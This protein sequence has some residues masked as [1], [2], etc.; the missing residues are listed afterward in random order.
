MI[1]TL[2]VFFTGKYF[3]IPNYQ[4]NYAWEIRNID[5]L[6]DDI[7]EGMDTNVG[8]YI[9]TFILSQSQEFNSYDVVDG[10]QR[11]TTLT[12]ILNSTINKL[13]C[14]TD[15]IINR[16]KFIQ[17]NSTKKWKLELLGDNDEFFKDLLSS[18]PVTPVKKSQRL[19]Q[20]A[21]NHINSRIQEIKSSGKENEFLNFIKNLE[22]M[23]FTESDSGKAIRIFQTVND[24]GK[25][26][27]NI[28]KAKS[29]LIYYSSRFLNGKYD[30]IINQSFGKMYHYYNEIKEISEEYGISLINQKNFTE[31][32][33]MRYHFIAYPNDKYDYNATANYVLDVFLKNVLKSKKS[34]LNNLESFIQE[35]V[36]DLTIFFENMLI[37]V[38]KVKTEKK[39]YKIFT[40]LGLSALLYPLVIRLETRKLL[41]KSIISKAITFLDLIEI[42]DLRVYKT[43]G[44]D[45]TR[46]ISYLAFDSKSIQEDEIEKRL[47][48][49][50][51]N[52]MGDTQ[53]KSS[54][55]NDVYG[56]AALKHIFIE[57]DEE[58]IKI[59]GNT[60]YSL[61][62]LMNLNQ[63][64]PTIEHVFAQEVRF[65]FPSRGFH[66]DEEYIA[67]IHKFGN[68]TILEKNLNSQAINKTPEQK[69]LDNIYSKSLFK[70]TETLNAEIKNNGNNFVKSDV[71]KRTSS[72]VNF[73]MTQ[74][75][76]YLNSFEI[77]RICVSCWRD[78]PARFLHV[79]VHCRRPPQVVRRGAGR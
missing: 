77:N 72:L 43:R 23:E 26:L 58:F 57:Y 7:L 1:N 6:F 34:D 22:A 45:P 13:T 4:R 49:F 69:V 64:T 68:L 48:S 52:F 27:S 67:K 12:M 47:I 71:D 59:N 33:I 28:D 17:T 36:E 60:P 21:Y 38:N 20:E 50:I 39:Y 14:D 40:L 29:L 32:S 75:S 10:Q 16:D 25:P 2:E 8:H 66:S 18:N 65:S 11:L 63:T 70:S 54:L 35:Y 24:R 46:D 53:F 9:G 41:D 78:R 61:K 31:D 44:T 19:L 15:R 62:D 55:E 56:N 42:T 74:W 51:K 79:S 73:C 30:D 5:D 76:L 37:I 3:S